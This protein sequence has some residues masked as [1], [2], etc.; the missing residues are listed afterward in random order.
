MKP[1]VF[2]IPIICG[3]G[4]VTVCNCNTPSPAPEADIP[5]PLTDAAIPTQIYE[6]IRR[7]V[8][9]EFAR[10][11]ERRLAIL[12]QAAQFRERHDKSHS[13]LVCEN[14]ALRLELAA[15]QAQLAGAI[16][17]LNE[18]ASWKE[19]EPVNGSF[20]EPHA[21]EAARNCLVSLQASR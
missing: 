17:T 16:N 15:T 12:D 10:G 13:Q 8:P 19:G 14:D 9:A 5:T 6:N 21:A 1:R 11:L 3:C 20:D 2:E 18:I 7:Y 4:G